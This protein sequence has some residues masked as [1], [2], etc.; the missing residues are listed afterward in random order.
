M[1]VLV[2]FLLRANRIAGAQ[3][4][5]SAFLLFSP[6]GELLQAWLC[7]QLVQQQSLHHLL[8]Y[9]VIL[10]FKGKSYC[11]EILNHITKNYL[12]LEPGFKLWFTEDIDQ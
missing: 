2:I 4:Q 6:A 1:T 3:D 12:T 7:E 10:D 5:L 8:K 9:I 11:L